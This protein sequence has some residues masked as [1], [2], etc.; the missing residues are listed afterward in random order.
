MALPPPPPIAEDDLD[1]FDVPPPPPLDM[2]DDADMAI[3]PPP[4]LESNSAN[5]QVDWIPTQ[6]IRKGRL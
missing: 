3:P 5:V 4:P 1:G 2:E 6:Y